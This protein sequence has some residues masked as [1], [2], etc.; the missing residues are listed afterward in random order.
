MSLF[1]PTL[2]LASLR[3]LLNGGV[4]AVALTEE[5]ILF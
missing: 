1:N 3:E 5:E 4:A 2:F